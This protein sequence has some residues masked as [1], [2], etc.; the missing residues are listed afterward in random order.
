MN[1]TN[2]NSEA[3]DQLALHGRTGPAISC[4]VVTSVEY[5]GT[6]MNDPIPSTQVLILPCGEL[7]KHQSE[8]LPKVEIDSNVITII[9]K[10]LLHTAHAQALLIQLYI[11]LLLFF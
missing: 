10:S 6:S 8:L 3:G 2:D 1:T 11:L 7:H 9:N 4:A 5:D